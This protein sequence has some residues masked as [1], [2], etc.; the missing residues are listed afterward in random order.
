MTFYSSFYKYVLDGTINLA[1]D[2]IKLA[3]VTSAYTPSVAH[4]VL[5]D[6]NSSPD[7]EVEQVA[8]PDNGYTTGGEEVTGVSVTHTDSPSQATLDADDVEWTALTATFRY[9][10]LYAE[11]SVGS[12]AIVNPLI[13][14]ILYDTEPEDVVV[15]GVD[16]KTKW[17]PNGI[18]TVSE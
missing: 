3:L 6:V 17:S 5:A 7:P 4:D 18:L 11:K 10:I 16:W 2:T 14:Y 8:S 9:G 12:P 15:N 1:S 13:A